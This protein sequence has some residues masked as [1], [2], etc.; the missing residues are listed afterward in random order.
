M[1]LTW[2]RE[3]LRKEEHLRCCLVGEWEAVM[4]LVHNL[5]LVRRWEVY[6][7]LGRGLSVKKQSCVNLLLE[8]QDPEGLEKKRGWGGGEYMFLVGRSCQVSLGKGCGASPTL[9][10]PKGV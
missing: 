1:D 6:Q 2:R 7:W 3:M 4:D 5:D 10:E 8:F 9:L